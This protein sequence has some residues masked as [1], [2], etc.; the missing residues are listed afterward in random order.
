MRKYY[1]IIFVLILSILKGN[2][3]FNEGKN[4]MG[5][6]FGANYSN[7]IGDDASDDF[8][9]KFSFS[10]GLFFNHQI[11]EYGSVETGLYFSPKGTKITFDSNTYKLSIY[12][13]ENRTFAKIELASGY[14]NKAYFLLGSSFGYNFL[15]ESDSGYGPIDVTESISNFEMCMMS[16]IQIIIRKVIMDFEY[17]YGLTRVMKLSTDTRNSTFIF[18]VGVILK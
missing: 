17:S 4:Y 9:S 10:G 2:S 18:S 13:I 16:G 1:I 7:I 15:S 3:E 6:K 8:D 14:T 5:I 12:Y 11:S